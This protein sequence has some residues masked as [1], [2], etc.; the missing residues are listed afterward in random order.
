MGARKPETGPKLSA[1]E[2]NAAANSSKGS[3]ENAAFIAGN[4]LDCI[5]ATLLS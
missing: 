2:K 5:M 3:A 4:I 1:N